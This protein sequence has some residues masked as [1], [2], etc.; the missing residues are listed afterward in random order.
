MYDCREM[1][2]FTES[3][4]LE[5]IAGY[6]EDYGVSHDHAQIEKHG[7]ESEGLAH[8][9]LLVLIQGW[10]H[11][12]PDLVDYDGE[13]QYEAQRYGCLQMDEELGGDVDVDE[14]HLERHLE[15]PVH[16]EVL[17]RGGKYKVIEDYPLETEDYDRE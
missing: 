8:R 11:E 13:S 10:C 17:T 4:T 12:L 15:P 5:E 6:G 7:C 16:E 9:R 2:F 14:F 1:V 3:L